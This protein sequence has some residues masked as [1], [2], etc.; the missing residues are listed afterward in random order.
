MKKNLVKLS[1]AFCATSLV[2]SCASTGSK[3]NDT[4]S[5][6]YQYTKS[7]WKSAKI[8]A[9]G[10]IPGII[11][12]TSE[13]GVLYVRTDMGGAYRYIP[14]SESWKPLTDFA[15]VEDYGRLGI[16]SIA[17]DPV[18]PN[19]VILA[20]GTYTNDWESGPSEM[21]VSQNYGDTFDR[22]KMYKSDGSP[23]KMGGNMPGR[24][25][26]ERLAID[27]N[28]N[29]IIYFGSFGDGLYKSSDYGYTWSE[30]K[31]F[32]VKG[33]VYDEGFHTYSH[34]DHY[35]GIL[36]VLFDPASG[37]QGEGS[38]NIYCGV[39]DTGYT[40]YESND[41]GESW[42]PLAGQPDKGHELTDVPYKGLDSIAKGPH[43][44]MTGEPC[45]CKKY[46]PIKCTYSP[47]G[48]M[49]ISY[50]H[51]FGPYS[52]SFW[53]GAIYK[54]NFAEKTWTDISLPKHDKD[55]KMVTL[56][57]GV[58]SVTVDYQNPDTMVASTLNEWFPDEYLYRSTDGGKTWDAIWKLDGYPK[59]V[60]KYKLDISAAPWL[61]WGTQA[62][63]PEETPKL[64]W[65]IMDIEIDPFDSD[66]LMYGT[67]AT[68]YGT[69]NLT[70]WDKGK[71]V[72]LTVMAAGIE[73]CAVLA[74]I[75][76]SK[77]VHLISGVGDIGGFV[78]TDLTKSSP[79][80]VNPTLSAVS[81]LDYAQE[82]P[83]FIIRMGDGK[84]MYSEDGGDNWNPT[85]S[86]IEGA[87]TDWGG[88]AAV[89]PDSNIILWSP[90]NKTACWTNDNGHKWNE[91]QNLPVGAIV[92]SDRVNSSK[93]YAFVK[94][95][96]NEGAFY[97][98]SDGGNSFK[99][100]NKNF[101]EDGKEVTANNLTAVIG[102]EG[103]LW[104]AAGKAG[105]YHSE[106]GGATW[107]SIPEFDNALVI[108]LGKAKDSNS[109]QALYTNSKY[110]GQYGIFRS[111]D[112]GKT[113][114][115]INDDLHQFGAADS[116]ITGDPRIYGRVYLGTN[117]RGIMYRDLE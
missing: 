6:E 92:V 5:A 45:S 70:D 10:M 100:V 29:K 1:L 49:I 17:T 52:S 35:F 4:K 107:T 103:H 2:L 31:S 113:W 43:A 18:E 51:G 33:N 86:F 95:S 50:N 62:A 42:H 59:R 96:K 44:H 21:L 36:W 71:S 13:K 14:E 67:G 38:K 11:Y 93:F 81:C 83:Y 78:H 15:G 115:R 7:G 99:L 22:I 64:G 114:L 69:H 40:I 66:T 112:K 88:T 9:G 89:S 27:P 90:K 97:M 19:R 104:L 28:N 61:D 12:N 55:G 48:E 56:D 57:R 108:G 91:C 102:L 85:E 23:L 54:Y 74:L 32:P 47:K 72:N 106:D 63:L 30:V 87:N 65:T 25:C 116:A 117:G 41:G 105:L 46:Y 94:A 53:G 16:A 68:I 110:R 75:S 60:N 76:P 26:G 73:E 79:M 37:S 111:D 39:A 109:Y 77:G 24:G 82:D 101:I 84:M 58:G 80:I 3:N 34:F 8:C 20:S 98:S